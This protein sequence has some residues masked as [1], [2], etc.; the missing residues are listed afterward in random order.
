MG[1]LERCRL[2]YERLAKMLIS[3]KAGIDHLADKLD[4]V[5]E[6]GRQ[7]TMTD[8][9]IVD[10]MYQCEQTLVHLQA[11]IKSGQEKVKAEAEIAEGAGEDFVIE[12]V[13]PSEADLM[14]SRPFNQRIN[15]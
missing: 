14:Q 7:I 11:Q 1:K 4:Q 8:D 9:T 13:Q 10:V 15:L 5:Q 6:D 3:V 2:K 12:P